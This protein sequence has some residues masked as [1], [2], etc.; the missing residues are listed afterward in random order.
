[1]ALDDLISG[2]DR[3]REIEVIEKPEQPVGLTAS[4]NPLAPSPLVA[5]SWRTRRAAASVSVSKGRS[6]LFGS[7]QE[8]IRFGF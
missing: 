4:R 7:G 5:R 1:M 6:I 8:M 2:F 3:T